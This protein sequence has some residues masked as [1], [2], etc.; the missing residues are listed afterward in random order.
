MCL[1]QGGY[2][3]GQ[4]VAPELGPE[5]VESNDEMGKLA[6]MASVKS[7]YREIFLRNERRN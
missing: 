2:Q 1:R 5:L 3:I 6:V 4:G 7:A